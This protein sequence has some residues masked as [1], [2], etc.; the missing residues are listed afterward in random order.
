[1]I[2]ICIIIS[3]AS[4]ILFLFYLAYDMRKFNKRLEKENQEYIEKL[5]EIYLLAP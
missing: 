5:L 3:V 1:M 2:E 4:L